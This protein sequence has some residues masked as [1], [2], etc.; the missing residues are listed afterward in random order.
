MGAYAPAPLANSEKIGQ[1]EEKVIKPTLRAMENEGMPYKGLL[2]AGL[3]NTPEGLK[4][5]EYNCRFGDPE[6]EVVLPLLESDLIPLMLS[7]IEG[8]IDDKDIRIKSGFAVD[9]VL[10][11][12]GYPPG[13]VCEIIFQC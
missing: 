2:Y 6:T 4:V 3:I 5:L 1:I 12:G 7:S 13:N 10:A 11:S 8:T 9:V